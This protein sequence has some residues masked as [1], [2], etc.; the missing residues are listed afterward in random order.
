VTYPDVVLDEAF[1]RDV[2]SA[3]APRASITSGDAQL[4]MLVAEFSVERRLIE[5]GYQIAGPAKLYIDGKYAGEVITFDVK[6]AP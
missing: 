1:T 3:L 4:A 5:S 2:R 6:L